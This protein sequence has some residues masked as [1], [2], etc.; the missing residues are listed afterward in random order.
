M[1]GQ[2]YLIYRYRWV[3]KKLVRDNY[4]IDGAFAS[5]PDAA[6]QIAAARNDYPVDQRHNTVFSSLNAIFCSTSPQ[7]VRASD[8]DARHTYDWWLVVDFVEWM[9][10]PAF[11]GN[12]DRHQRT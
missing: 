4:P 7:K 10:Q 8:L 12:Q 1:S 6:V 9:N 2:W 11:E 5:N 3:G